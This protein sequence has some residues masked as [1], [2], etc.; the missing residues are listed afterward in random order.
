MLNRNPSGRVRPVYFSPF[1]LIAKANLPSANCC[2]YK[3][4]ALVRLAEKEVRQ[5]V[6]LEHAPRLSPRANAKKNVISK[7]VRRP[8][9]S[10]DNQSVD[11][12]LCVMNFLSKSPGRFFARGFN[13]R[14][15][16]PRQGR[17]L[18]PAWIHLISTPAKRIKKRAIVDLWLGS[19]HR[20]LSLLASFSPVQEQ[21]WRIK[22]ATINPQRI[23]VQ[24][25]P[26]IAV[27]SVIWVDWNSTPWH[28]RL[29]LTDDAACY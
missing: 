13:P 10:P 5:R 4:S 18:I 23:E 9:N 26:E 17:I 15:N 25:S 20:R 21:C 22:P 14:T 7:V 27:A 8:F 6:S 12:S 1:S 24:R 19:S 16:K 2:L 28:E 3:L 11:F 29:F